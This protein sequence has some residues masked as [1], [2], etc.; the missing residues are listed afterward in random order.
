VPSAS[1]K[2][3]LLHSW[4][5]FGPKHIRQLGNLSMHYFFRVEFQEKYNLALII[6][7]VKVWVAIKAYVIG[8]AVKTMLDI[9]LVLC[10]K[11]YWVTDAMQTL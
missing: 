7:E 6:F 4:H 8:A 9:A 2:K 11:K 1:P 5:L 3:P 10:F